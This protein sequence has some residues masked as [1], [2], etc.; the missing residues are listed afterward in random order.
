[1]K[2]RILALAS[3]AVLAQIANASAWD[4]PQPPLVGGIPEID[5]VTDGDGVGVH[6]VNGSEEGD[7]EWY[8]DEYYAEKAREAGIDDPYDTSH[9]PLWMDSNEPEEDGEGEIA[10]EEDGSS[11]ATP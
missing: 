9:R 2:T 7:L 5:L 1:M 6:V 8:M 11:S 4:V 10:A 3:I